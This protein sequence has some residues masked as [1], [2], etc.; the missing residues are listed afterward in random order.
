MIDKFTKF[1]SQETYKTQTELG[2]KSELKESIIYMKI[3]KDMLSSILLE[4]DLK[5]MLKIL[6]YMF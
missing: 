2:I 1:V 6:Y 5:K 3:M 4:Q